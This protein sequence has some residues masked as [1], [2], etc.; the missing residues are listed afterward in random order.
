[1]SSDKTKLAKP[2]VLKAKKTVSYV[3][4]LPSV[5]VPQSNPIDIKEKPKRKSRAKKIPTREEALKDLSDGLNEVKQDLSD[6][7]EDHMKLQ[8]F[9]F[10]KQLKCVPDMINEELEALEDDLKDADEKYQ[11]LLSLPAEDAQ[12]IVA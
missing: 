3:E 7:K 2:R 4:P 1:M 6:L 8:S 11:F 10:Y 9:D 5:D 12:T